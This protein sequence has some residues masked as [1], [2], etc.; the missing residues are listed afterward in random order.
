MT[1]ARQR[2]AGSK[3]SLVDQKA[4][5]ANTP[6]VFYASQPEEPAA[7]EPLADPFASPANGGVVESKRYFGV[8]TYLIAQAL[9][10][11]RGTFRQLSLRVAERYKSR[12]YPTPLFEG[13]LERRL[14]FT[15]SLTPTK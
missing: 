13:D 10:D 12:P 1:Q 15:S 6:V 9:P 3:A 11:W 8:F 5:S 2:R 14:P 4:A 7:E